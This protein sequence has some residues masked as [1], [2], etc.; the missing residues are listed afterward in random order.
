MEHGNSQ[1]WDGIREHLLKYG[2]PKEGQGTESKSWVP[3]FLVYICFGKPPYPE[4]T[5]INIYK[6]TWLFH[7]CIF[8]CALNNIY[9]I[10]C[11]VY[12][13]I[14]IYTVYF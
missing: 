7:R 5:W 1:E 12:M 14:Y 6:H 3:P 13:Y 4:S 10:H 8:L 11:D 2:S 9:I